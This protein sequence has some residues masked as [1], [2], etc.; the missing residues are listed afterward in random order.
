LASFLSRDQAFDQMV[1][2]WKASRASTI[3]VL[4]HIK[5]DDATAFSEDDESDYTS[6]GY[7]YS[8]DEDEVNTEMINSNI[9]QGKESLD[10]NLYTQILIY[11][12]F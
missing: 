4:E 8:E 9:N 6:S 5:D 11:F 10:L 12:F 2:I 7:S 3:E 1:E